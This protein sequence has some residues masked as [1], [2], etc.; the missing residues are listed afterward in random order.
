[1]MAGPVKLNTLCQADGSITSHAGCQN[2]ND[3]EGNQCG[4]N[5]KCMDHEDPTGVHKD[6]YH[7]DCDSGFEEKVLGDGTRI[8]E[9]TPDCPEGACLPGSCQDL[10]NDYECNCPEGYYEGENPQEELPHDCLP[11]KCG[12]PPNKPHAKTD[13]TADIFFNSEPVLYTCEEGYTLDG[14]AEGDTTFEITCKADKSFS[15]SPEC[16]AVVCGEAP[17]VEKA[18]YDK[19]K[20]FEFPNQIPYSCETGYTV[21]GKAS[22]ADNFKGKCQ[23]DGTFTD[24]KQ[25]L[26]VECPGIPDQPN[27]AFPEGADLVFPEKVEVTCVRG[28]ALDKDKHDEKKYEISCKD[29]GKLDVPHDGCVPIDCGEA[30]AIEHTTSE[31]STIFGE[32]LTYTADHGYSVDGTPQGA[33][34]FE[35]KCGPD[36]KFRKDADEV[37]LISC[38]PPAAVPHAKAPTIDGDFAEFL[39]KPLKKIKIKKLQ[40]H[41]SKLSPHRSLAHRL[42][43]RQEYAAR[44]NKSHSYKANATHIRRKARNREDI[45]AKFGNVIKYECEEGYGVDENGDGLASADET[46]GFTMHC[47]VSGEIKP[48]GDPSAAKAV[49]PPPFECLPIHCPLP[50]EGLPAGSEDDPPS[51]GEVDSKVRSFPIIPEG[52]PVAITFGMKQEFACSGGFSLDGSVD[53]GT[54]YEET[55]EANGKLT[56]DNKCKDIDWCEISE[57]GENGKCVDGDSDYTCDCNEGFKNTLTEA[58]LDTCVQI[59]ECDTQGGEGK[60]TE[61]GACHDE[62]LKYKCECDEGYKNEDDEDGLDTCTP[63]ICGEPP[64]IADASTPMKGV[65]IPFPDS[66]TFSCMSGFSLD[67][68]NTGATS[69]DITCEADKS[70]SGEKECQ[71]IKCGETATVEKATVNATELK[72]PEVA[73]Y[74]CD[75]GY[76]TSGMANGMKKFS[77]ACTAEGMITETEECKPVRCG[78]PVAVLFARFP[79][80]SVTFGEK[81]EYVCQEGY[82]TTGEA[83][84]EA[85]FEVECKETGNF[86]D[87]KRCMPVSCGIPEMIEHSVMPEEEFYYP[88]RFQVACEAGHTVDTDPDGESTFVVKCMKD[89]KFEGLE[90]CKKVTCGK[91]ENTEGAETSDSAK[92]FEE[93]AEWTCKAGYTV[94]GKPKG[95]TKFVKQCQADGTYADA[96]PA[97]CIDINFC[98]GNPCGK[99]GMC[100]DSGPG[101]VDPGYECDC[102]EGYEVKEGPDGPKCGADDCAGDPCGE[103]GTCFDLTLRDPPGPAGSYTCECEDGYEI[104]ETEGKPTCVRSTCG[105]VTKL[106]NLEMDVNNDPVIEVHTWKGDEPENDVG[107]GLPILKSFDAVTYKCKEGFST[108]GGTGP[109]SKEF[110]ISCESHGRLERPLNPEKECQPVKCANFMLPTVPHTTVT[111]AK[112]SFFEFGDIVNFKCD[113][114]FTINGQATGPTSFSMPCQKTGKFP[115]EH[116]NCQPVSCGV[117]HEIPNTLR[118]TTKKIK[119]GM[120]VT[121]MCSD[122]FTIDGEVDGQPAFAGQC[123]ADGEITFYDEESG[124]KIPEPSCTPI[125]CGAPPQ[126]A[127]AMLMQAEPMEEEMMFIQKGH[128]MSLED[129]IALQ[130]EKRKNITMKVKGKGKGKGKHKG[131]G[132]MKGKLGRTHLLARVRHKEDDEDY[133]YGDEDIAEIGNVQYRD[134]D[135]EVICNEG[136]SIDGIP[137]GRTWFTMRCKSDGSFT[138]TDLKCEMPKFKVQGIATDAQSARIRL[139]KAKIQFTNEFDEIVADVDTDA[140]GYYD[141]MLPQ[142]KVT[143]TASKSGYINQVKQLTVSTSIR[144]GQGADVAMSKVLPPGAWRVVVSW[145]SRSR[146]IDSHT[147][148]GAGE[149]VHVFWPRRYRSR[150]AP[151]TGGISVDLDRDDVNGFGPETTTFKNVGKCKEKGNCLIKFKIKNY[152]RRDKALGDSGVKIVLYNGNSVHSKYQINPDVGTAKASGY[153]WPIFTIDASEGATKVVYEGDLRLPAYISSSKTGI[154]NWWGTLDRQQWSRLPGGAILYGLHTTNGRNIYN[155]EQGRYYKVQNYKSISCRNENWWASFVRGGWSLCPS[156]QFMAGLYRTGHMRDWNHGTYQLEEAMCCKVDDVGYG[157]C[158]EQDILGGAGWSNCAP[159]NGQPAA[160]VGL[161]RSTRGDIRGIDKAKC[162]TMR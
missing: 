47:D 46:N 156:G 80:N 43:H 109:E 84:G 54:E 103:G 30:P 66:V 83:D 69:F 95:L 113:E 53:G 149:S 115:G 15:E 56:E 162:C 14:A 71:P 62:T 93:T 139:K 120:G 17:S 8:C 28:F 74:T 44:H 77:T 98:H 132:K 154:Q 35:V 12:S 148:F 106:K 161:Y 134:P 70:F 152:S 58:G 141:A 129:I 160:M 122:G 137:G 5:G 102:H 76:T 144:R 10:V 24:I 124:N 4:E 153:M 22:G 25:C 29:D 85:K 111:N 49:P 68:T 146:D 1:M 121:Y 125:S 119:Y 96:S 81:V 127:N 110:T 38:G 34:T 150:G 126:I 6:D 92:V 91:P 36:G 37:K 136:Y 82:T 50:S 63:V 32:V 89:G 143:L 101:K 88:N 105:P 147:Y 51:E 59:D 86:T 52:E 123:A 72:F 21:N 48:G 133:Y 75:K 45:S 138:N 87:A 114:G 117:P 64:E 20:V 2:M 42:T 151:K 128:D 116:A 140:S 55:C 7:C 16:I 142:G 159:V 90:E 157:Q 23:A 100:I 33:K 108:D 94:D 135:I 11:V 57:C 26:P 40:D 13:E 27:A 79:L 9:N 65:K 73:G 131:K 145:D 3:C 31:G 60:C 130:E 61:N 107:T 19:E 78:K 118:S 39:Q 99:N 18:T 104:V 67:G 158:A 97:D 112:E 155:I 41:K